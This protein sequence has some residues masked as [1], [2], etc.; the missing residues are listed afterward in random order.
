MQ[1]NVRGGGW[2]EKFFAKHTVPRW[3]KLVENEQASVMLLEI[4]A[5]HIA[6]MPS[7]CCAGGCLVTVFLAG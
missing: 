5:K 3:L 1:K 6:R 2:L 4:Y 7:A